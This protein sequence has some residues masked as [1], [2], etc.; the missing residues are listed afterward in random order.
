MFIRCF[1]LGRQITMYIISSN[2]TNRV[3]HRWTSTSKKKNIEY[4]CLQYS[5]QDVNTLG[6]KN[7]KRKAAARTQRRV[8]TEAKGPFHKSVKDHCL[9]IERGRPSRK[10]IAF[11]W[12]K[13]VYISLDLPRRIRRCP[14]HDYTLEPRSAKPLIRIPFSIC[15]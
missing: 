10:F 7:P 15:S 5:R 11:E 2:F 4:E 9:T 3:Q 13:N 12:P 8:D 1:F 6:S 14:S